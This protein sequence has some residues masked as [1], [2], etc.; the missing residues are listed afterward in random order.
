MNNSSLKLFC[1]IAFA[2][3]MAACSKGGSSSG[4]DHGTGGGGNPSPIDTIAP[5]LDIFTPTTAQVF[6]TVTAVNITGKITDDLGLY[7]GT[8]RITNDANG[9]LWREQAYEI[10]YILAYN[11][12]ISETITTPGDYTITVRFEDHGFNSATKSVK[13]K[14]NP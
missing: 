7:R 1:F 11:F 12:N 2:A 6:N 10:H 14:V 13:I 4:P 9:S 5:I 3:V 8:I